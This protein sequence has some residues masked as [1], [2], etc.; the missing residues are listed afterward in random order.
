MEPDTQ[1]PQHNFS[2][3]EVII[4]HIS[5]T[6]SVASGSGHHVEETIPTFIER[7]ESF[8]NPPFNVP[9]GQPIF[10]PPSMRYV[11]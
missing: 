11:D 9:L 4:D 7:L 8:L 1:E 6:G 10:Y 3:E 2:Y 5:E